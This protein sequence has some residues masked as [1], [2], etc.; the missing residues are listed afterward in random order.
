VFLQWIPYVL[1][2]A[3]LVIVGFLVTRISSLLN[4]LEREVAERTSEL[5]EA[6]RKLKKAVRIDPLTGLLNQSAFQAEAE[7]EIKRVL[8]S[9]RPFTLILADIDSLQEVND[10][11]GR[12]LGDVVLRR[13]AGVLSSQVREVDRLARWGGGEFILLLPETE[14]VGAAL[15]AEKLRS[16]VAEERFLHDGDALAVTLTLGIAGHRRGE[17]LDTTLARAD[18]ALIQGKR[19]GRNRVMIGSYKGLTLVR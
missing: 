16:S 10:R 5:G 7:A 4:R 17:T 1:V 12:Q 11:F 14:Q 15:V 13:V 8:R 9:D 6:N 19:R 3:L 2:T 18:T